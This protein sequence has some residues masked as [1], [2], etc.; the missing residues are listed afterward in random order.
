MRSRFG[1]VLVA[2]VA[3]LALGAGAAMSASAHEF[4]VEGKSMTESG[5]TEE[6]VTSTVGHAILAGPGFAIECLSNSGTGTIKQGGTGGMAFKLGT[7]IVSKPEFC[8]VKPIIVEKTV[9]QLVEVEGKL[10]DRFAP[11]KAGGYLFTM[12]FENNGGECSL[13]P[14][15]LPVEGQMTGLVESEAESEAAALNFTTK[16]GSHLVLPGA[17]MT[18]TFKDTV[19]LSGVN[20]GKKWSAKK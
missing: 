7:C 9:D 10:A 6:T 14:T 5:L 2:L 20:K 13:F 11:A 16:S 19:K 8:K 12:Q 4:Y 17:L 3:V 1:S 15:E 18:A